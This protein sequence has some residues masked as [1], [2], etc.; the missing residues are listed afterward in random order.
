MGQDALY[1]SINTVAARLDCSASTVRDYVRR[2]DLPAPRKIAGLVRWKWSDIEHSL[3]RE[4]EIDQ[5]AAS[6]PILAA[7]NGAHVTR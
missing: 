1:C 2:G 6:D 3:D 7:I 4:A 5:G